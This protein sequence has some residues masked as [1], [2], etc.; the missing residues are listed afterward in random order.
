MELF[1][2]TR[3][4]HAA[5]Q[6]WQ[7]RQRQRRRRRIVFGT[8]LAILVLIAGAV[9]YGV[10]ELLTLREVAD[11]PGTGTTEVVV[12]VEQG[13]TTRAIA[14]RLVSENV[15]KSVRAFT[16]AAEDSD[17][18]RSVQPGYYVM[19]H[20]MSGDAAVHQLL[21]PAA[22]VGQL[23]I[24][25]GLQLDDVVLPDGKVV[26]GIL[27]RISQ[28]SCAELNGVSTC[29]PPEELRRAIAATAPATLGVP[30]WALQAVLRVEP[31]RRLEGL[32]MPGNYH[33]RPG[34]TGVELLVQMMSTSSAR[35]QA[36]G[37]PAGAQATG[38]TPYEVLIIA[39]IIQREAIPADFGKVA[40]V[41]YNRL[42]DGMP[43]QM[44]STIN[45]PLR[46][47]ELTTSDADRATPGP[48][49]TYLNRGLPP[50]PIATPSAEALAA[51]MHPEPGPWRYFVKCRA[52]G[53]SCF[54]VTIEQH[55]AA[56]ADARRR[57]IF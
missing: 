49:N 21:A 13:D 48:Y 19:R 17:Q 30:D 12:Q 34:S 50:S 56:V 8:T 6:T 11:Y 20:R 4:R 3:S 10:R 31:A 24:R 45:Y 18:I 27:S 57:G 42:A 5:R 2:D 52:D 37:M 1:G 51:A 44:D 29:V 7:R 47:Q 22:R 38:Y 15:V 43:L 35:L 36:T 14:A 40:R 53:T 39:S 28:A 46:R 16:L 25:S 23:S 32:I 41:V 55:R 9:W 33:V 54:S 26:P